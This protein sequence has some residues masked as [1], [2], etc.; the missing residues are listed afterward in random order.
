[1]VNKNMEGYESKAKE[2]KEAN[3]FELIHSEANKNSWEMPE[4]CN[5]ID[6][7][8][9]EG[10]TTVCINHNSISGESNE[11]ESSLVEM[12]NKIFELMGVSDDKVQSIV[13]KFYSSEKG[14]ELDTYG[15]YKFKITIDDLVSLGLFERKDVAEVAL[16]EVINHFIDQKA[17]V[18]QEVKS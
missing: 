6:I 16:Y 13:D 14:E 4:Q 3:K 1:M 17:K 15:I 7:A 9:V 18:S 12:I 2:N 5:I 8:L 10:G 11:Y